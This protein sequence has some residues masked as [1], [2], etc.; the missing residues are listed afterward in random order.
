MASDP[1]TTA[2]INM[3]GTNKELTSA[4]LSSAISNF[5]INYLSS[6]YI[7]SYEAIDFISTRNP[8]KLSISF[9]QPYY[10]HGTQ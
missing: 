3:Y 6:T 2:F 7:A 5:A 10:N 4:S 1:S 8:D 9:N